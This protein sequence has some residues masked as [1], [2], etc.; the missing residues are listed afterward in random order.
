MLTND[1]YFSPENNMK[2]MGSSQFSSFLRCEAAAMADLDGTYPRRVTDALLIGS[3]VDAYYEGTLAKFKSEHP[4]IFTQRGELKTQYKHA[5]EIIERAERDE[6][7]KRYMSGDKQVIFTGEIS[8]VPYKVKVDSYHEGKCIV[9]LKC[10]RDFNT[11]WDDKSK[12][13]RNFIEHWGYLRQAAIY[14]EIVRQNTGKKLPFYIA[15]VTKETEPDLG[16]IYIPDEYL[17]EPL[18]QV[19]ELSPRFNMIKHGEIEP[20]RCGCCDFCKHSKKLTEPINY[21]DMTISEVYDVQ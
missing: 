8:G 18:E 6:M 15:A 7:F 11:I 13:R 17:V 16:I 20:E 9:D 14:Q 12:T 3:Y 4:E 5:D 1:N 2:Y 10:I 19:K 21:A